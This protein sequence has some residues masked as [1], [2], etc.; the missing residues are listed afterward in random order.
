MRVCLFDID[1]TLIQSGGAGMGALKEAMIK[2]FG[3]EPPVQQV[4]VHGRTDRAIAADLFTVYSIEQ[5]D[6]N[7]Q[8]F[9]TAYLEALPRLLVERDGD[10]LPGIGTL[11]DLL[12]SQDDIRLGLLT[13]NTRAGAEIKLGHYGLSHY[14]SFGGFGDL[15]HDRDDVARAA[16][17]NARS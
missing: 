3:I 6:A 13:G 11:L 9:R 4:P 15:H 2:A 16:F 8:R 7:W 17:A 5:T 1:G 10:V 12:R 14:F